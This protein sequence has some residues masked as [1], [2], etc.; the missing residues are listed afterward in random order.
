MPPKV[1]KGEYIETDTGN[2]ISR[3]SQIHGT[4]HIILG[5]KTVIQGE[6]VIRGD[7]YRTSTSSGASGDQGGQQPATST[8]SVAITIGRY[9]YISK[10]AVLR[11]PSRL[12]RGVHSFYPLKIGDHVFVGERAVVEAAS[13]GNHVHIG[14]DAVIGSMAIL[15][16]FA[17]VLDGAVVAPGMVVPSWCVV[18]GA[19]ARIVGE[20]GE[21]YGVEGAEGGMARE[22]YR[23]VGR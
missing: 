3:R 17:Y 8:P 7:L 9:S 6:A 15:K 11:P 10:Q 4:Q 21:G 5:G 14:R 13:V 19:P 2:K 23:L 20:V 16:D 12:H 18:G 22:R 1:A